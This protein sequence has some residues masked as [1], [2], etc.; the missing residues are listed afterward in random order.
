MSFDLFLHNQDQSQLSANDLVNYFNLAPLFTRGDYSGTV[1]YHYNNE[2]TGVYCTFSWPATAKAIEDRRLEFR[3]NYNRPIGFPQETFPFVEDICRHFNLLVEDVQEN[4]IEAASTPRLL[5]SWRTHNVV[6]VQALA[7]QGM[8]LRYLPED[9]ALDWWRYCRIKR[10]FEMSLEEDVF[11]PDVYI[12]QN[13]EQEL[14]RFAVLADGCAQFLPVSDYVWV[15]RKDSADQ[16]ENGF[17]SYDV[18]RDRLSPFLE[19]YD[20]FGETLLGIPENNLTQSSAMV[21]QLALA[22][23]DLSTFTRIAPDGFHNVKL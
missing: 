9:K 3:L 8:Q 17:V 21:Q 19:Q 6:A 7:A 12:F 5:K 4:T 15:E 16:V 1:Q 18:L 2:D 23:V 10:S 13:P 14:F 22:E 20:A 11:V